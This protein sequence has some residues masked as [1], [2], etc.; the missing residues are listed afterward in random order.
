MSRVSLFFFLFAVGSCLV[1]C[2]LVALADDLVPPTPT[3]KKALETFAGPS[4]VTISLANRSD[5][6]MWTPP[7]MRQESGIIL[8]WNEDKLLILRPSDHEP[9][10]IITGTVLRVEHTFRNPNAQKLHESYLAQRFGEVIPLAGKVIGSKA[11]AP[12]LSRWEQKMVLAMVVESCRNNKRWEAGCTLFSSLAKQSPPALLAASIPI[13]W[14]DST[15]EIPD[16]NALRTQ[17]QTWINDPNEYLQL[18]GA[19]WSLDGDQRTD[20]IMKLKALAKSSKTSLISDYASAQLWRTIPP[21]EF[22]NTQQVERNVALRDRMFLGAQA[23]P[24]LLLAERFNKAGATEL[25]LREWTRLVVLHPDQRFLSI[26]ATNSAL[27]ILR[28]SNRQEEAAKLD[29]LSR[30][31]EP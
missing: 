17:S 20:A 14:F 23:G 5:L 16:R 10:S 31:N 1:S 21:N 8:D 6:G 26:I 13:P 24:T 18:M 2:R 3:Y 30:K 27:Q 19:S 22:V 28:T 15:A 9:T 12:P 7:E 29:A 4:S 25:A 11:E